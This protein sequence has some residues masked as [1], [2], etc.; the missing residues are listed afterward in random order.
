MYTGAPNPRSASLDAAVVFVHNLVTFVFT[1][2]EDLFPF[3]G[4]VLTTVSCRCIQVPLVPGN[5]PHLMSRQWSAGAMVSLDLPSTE[6]PCSPVSRPVA[7][8]PSR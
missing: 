8:G 1:D 4:K 3:V 6:M 7:D 5:G 2:F